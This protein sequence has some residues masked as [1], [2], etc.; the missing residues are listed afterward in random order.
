MSSTNIKSHLKTVKTHVLKFGQTKK[1]SLKKTGFDG[2]T[3]TLICNVDYFLST[4]DR[5]DKTDQSCLK[6]IKI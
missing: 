4:K 5:F 6:R 3:Y 1:R 2:R